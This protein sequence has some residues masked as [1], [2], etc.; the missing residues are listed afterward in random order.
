MELGC[1][2][3]S[4]PFCLLQEAVPNLVFL[5]VRDKKQNKT[6]QQQQQQQKKKPVLPHLISVVDG[7]L[8][9]FTLQRADDKRG[10]FY[11]IE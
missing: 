3:L 8:E 6:K 11:S 4:R 10:V 2:H 5:C 9:T 7:S 1:G